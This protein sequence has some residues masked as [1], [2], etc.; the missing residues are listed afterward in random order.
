MKK[1]ILA[2]VAAVSLGFSAMAVHAAEDGS[3]TGAL[4]DNHCGEKQKDEAS[5]MK[6]PTSC[7]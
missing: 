1:Y 5:A 2:A 4:L 6:H 7:A 3:W